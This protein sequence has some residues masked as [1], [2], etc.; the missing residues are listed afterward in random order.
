MIN[1]PKNVKYILSTLN[2]NGYE[3]YIVG[4][5]VRDSLM[6]II[7]HDWDITTSALPEQVKA[8][9]NHTYDTGIKHGT[10]TV[11]LD[12]IGYE[13]TT[14]RV[15]GIYKDNRRPS[16]VTFTR[17]LDEDL[18]RR[19]FTMNAI[20]YNDTTGLVD[21]F[22]GMADIE[23]KIIRGVGK[24]SA[25]FD[26]DALRMLRAVRFSAQLGFDIEEETYAAIKNKADLIEHIS[27][28]RIREEL[29]K[30]LAG[31]HVSRMPLLWESGL[32]RVISPMAADMAAMC[33]E[34]IT[35]ETAKAPSGG[36]ERLIV[37]LYRLGADNAQ[38]LL[39][40]L[41]FD[42]KTI[43]T[44]HT[45]I[46]YGDIS[47]LRSRY[48]VKKLLSAIDRENFELLIT[49][50]NAQGEDTDGI[51]DIYQSVIAAGE[52]YQIKDLKINGNIIM[53]RGLAKGKDVG[54]R[55]E[56]VLDR[57]L[58]EPELNR[59]EELIKVAEKMRMK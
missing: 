20:A 50:K 31:R 26:E 55:L 32:L 52:P 3:A 48:D 15:D 47:G 11:L 46:K 24:S 56:A 41:K 5:C 57:V 13:V 43:K 44:V 12:K 40:E 42:N 54:E 59:E 39:K 53:E 25:R 45:V 30:L 16:T 51:R 38:K 27:K 9:F 7:P 35:A 58:A 28:E 17:S 37:L 23:N 19:D 14:Y 4:G 22:G 33:G 21:I 6:G 1:L 10:I 2:S 8:L 34:K 29:L 49:V 18:I 36:Y